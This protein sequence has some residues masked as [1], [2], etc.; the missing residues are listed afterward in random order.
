MLTPE[1]VR[2]NAD[3]HRRGNT[4]SDPVCWSEND[5]REG[6][7]NQ[8]GASRTKTKPQ[9][10]RPCDILGEIIQGMKDAGSTVSFYESRRPIAQYGEM[11]CGKGVGNWSKRNDM[12]NVEVDDIRSVRTCHDARGNIEF[13]SYFTRSLIRMNDITHFRLCIR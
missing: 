8:R 2:D 7:G 5:A 12:G 3:E 4:L 10:C 13:F 9:L 11:S 6:R 1:F